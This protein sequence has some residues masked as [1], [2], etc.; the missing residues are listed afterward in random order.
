MQAAPGPL[1]RARNDNQH[2]NMTKGGHLMIHAK[3][4]ATGWAAALA[5]AAAVLVSAGS[6]AKAEELIRCAYPYWF[7]AGRPA[8]IAVPGARLSP[9]RSYT[10]ER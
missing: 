10:K 2:D 9:R 3:R 5:V 7:G 4:F 1:A 8:V 6:A